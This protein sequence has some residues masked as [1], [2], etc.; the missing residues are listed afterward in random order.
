MATSQSNLLPTEHEQ[1]RLKWTGGVFNREAVWPKE[2]DVAIIE[3]IA[4]KHLCPTIL[5]DHDDALF[6]V[7]FFAQ[8]AFN[9]LYWI[10]YGGHAKSYMFRVSLPLDPFFKVES[11]VATLAYVRANTTIPVA[12]VIAWDS[13][14]DTDLGYEWLLTEMI[15]GVTLYDVWR[16]VPWEQKLKL[17]EDV[18]K[19]VAQL[20]SSKFHAV[21]SLYFASALQEGGKERTLSIGKD[22]ER[23]AKE[24]EAVSSDTAKVA[25][26][27]METKISILPIHTSS[28]H[29]K[30]ESGKEDAPPAVNQVCCEDLSEAKSDRRVQQTSCSAK[31]GVKA[32]AEC[33]TS[34][35]KFT[36]DHM[37]DPLFFM[38]ARMELRANRGP[39]RNSI[40]W[41]E[42]LINVQV[43][44]TNK[45][46]LLLSEKPDDIEGGYDNDL[47]EEAPEIKDLCQKYREILPHIFKEEEEREANFTLHHHDL[48]AANI[49]VHPDTF[50]IAGILDWE[51][52]CVV[53]EWKAEVEPEFLQD[54]DFEWETEE[55]PIPPS[56]DMEKDQY[57]IEAR[58]RWDYK[59]LR[60]HFN[61]TIKQILTNTG[62]ADDFDFPEAETKR[63]VERNIS[64]IVN[65]TRSAKYWLKKY[66]NG[67]VA[68]SDSD[69]SSDED[70][71]SEDSDGG[72]N[73]SRAQPR[74]EDKVEAPA[75]EQSEEVHSNGKGE[76]QSIDIQNTQAVEAATPPDGD[77]LSE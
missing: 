42:A 52:T 48:N 55:P 60:Q 68:P 61:A 10:S 66:Q 54:A 50:E 38:D 29:L 40:E 77:E 32:D 21:G 15:E 51:M 35:E 24:S 11:E 39:F 13:N 6:E 34:A 20:R 62:Q 49:L 16:E 33:A 46:L 47:L 41:M 71:S 65:N 7:Q 28:A 36:I 76:A 56:Y 30:R 64:D 69:A 25:P 53:P 45:G 74:E 44:W 70:S 22:H 19:M 27:Q 59:Q 4:K 5:S 73:D 9:K 23:G 8:G 3:K 63:E 1:N 43:E 12:R 31:E 57:A 14:W 17:T 18:A 2:P 26:E 37:F 58:D 72:D 75:T 67:G